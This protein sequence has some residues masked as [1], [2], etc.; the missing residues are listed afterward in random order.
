MKPWLIDLVILIGAF[1]AASLIALATSASL[2]HAFT[3]GQ[4][5]FAAALAYVLLKR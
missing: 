4:L 5:A 2:G 1:A 3:F